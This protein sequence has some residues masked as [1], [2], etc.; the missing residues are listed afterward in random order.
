MSPAAAS[1]GIVRFFLQRS[2]RDSAAHCRQRRR[3]CCRQHHNPHHDQFCRRSP[4]STALLIAM[5]PS[6]RT[7]GLRRRPRSPRKRACSMSAAFCATK[8]SRHRLLCQLLHH[9]PRCCCPLLLSF[10]SLCIVGNLTSCQVL[11][12]GKVVINLS[13][14]APAGSPPPHTRCPFLSFT[15]Q[16]RE[17]SRLYGKLTH[18]TAL[19]FTCICIVR[20]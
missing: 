17:T 15:F 16:K 12:V 19:T 5:S 11:I 3:Q 4:Q 2:N 8:C 1:A 7:P 14:I 20:L 18:I 13:A 6:L 9:W 10:I